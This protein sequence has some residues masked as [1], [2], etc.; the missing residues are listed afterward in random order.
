M[1]NG[2]WAANSGKVAVNHFLKTKARSC[3][4]PMRSAKPE[5][6]KTKNPE[7]ETRNS[8]FPLDNILRFFI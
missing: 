6:V 7:L 5:D 4:F 1:A 8:L 3:S 2:R